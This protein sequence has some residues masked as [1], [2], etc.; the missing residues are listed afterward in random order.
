MTKT[1]SRINLAA[2]MALISSGLIRPESDMRLP[3]IGLQKAQT[4]FDLERINKAEEKRERKRL[5]RIA[6]AA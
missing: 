4:S 5:K 1:D 2:V 3:R 6:E